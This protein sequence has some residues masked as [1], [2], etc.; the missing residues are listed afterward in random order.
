MLCLPLIS[1]FTLRSHQPTYCFGDC[2]TRCLRPKRGVKLMKR[3]VDRTRTH[4]AKSCFACLSAQKASKCHMN[5]HEPYPG[6]LL[7]NG[8]FEGVCIYQHIY[9]YILQISANYHGKYNTVCM[10]NKKNITLDSDNLGGLISSGSQNNFEIVT[11]ES[12]L[13]KFLATEKL[14]QKKR[15][16]FLPSFFRGGSVKL[17]GFSTT[18]TGGISP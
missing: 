10:D 11:W 3:S 14:P 13:P 5:H 18:R 7:T 16:V 2:T 15:I 17:Q 8:V 9:I 1:C 12:T 4:R 6:W